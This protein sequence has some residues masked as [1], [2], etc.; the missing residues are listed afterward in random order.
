MPIDKNLPSLR[1]WKEGI[2][3]PVSRATHRERR[4]RGGVLHTGVFLLSEDVSLAQIHIYLRTDFQ[5]KFAGTSIDLG[6]NTSWKGSLVP[7][8]HSTEQ[9]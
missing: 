5:S 8:H 9:T 6:K 3:T 4:T 1:L 7:L 2:I